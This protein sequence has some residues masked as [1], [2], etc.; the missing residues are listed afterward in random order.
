MPSAQVWPAVH[1]DGGGCTREKMEPGGARR[2]ARP[3][4]PLAGRV[5]VLKILHKSVASLRATEVA[6]WGL[7]LS[8][9]RPPL[10]SGRLIQRKCLQIKFLKWW[11]GTESNRRHEDFQS[12]ALPTELPSH[13]SGTAKAVRAGREPINPSARMATGNFGFSRVF[14]ESFENHPSFPSAH[15]G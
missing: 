15:G 13:I 12:S 10:V 11:L 3:G 9:N 1:D 8:G 2:V 4:R 7:T 14:Q 5:A 6:I